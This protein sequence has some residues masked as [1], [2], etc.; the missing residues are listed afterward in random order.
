MTTTLEPAPPEAPGWEPRRRRVPEIGPAWRAARGRFAG[1]GLAAQAGRYVALF[2]VF[3]VFI[4]VLF[5]SVLSVAYPRSCG[6]MKTT[7]APRARKST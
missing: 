2:L 3:T 1:E 5:H 7:R 6:Q 4:E